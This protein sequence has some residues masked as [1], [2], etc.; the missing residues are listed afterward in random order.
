MGEEPL[1]RLRTPSI[2][3]AMLSDLMKKK[4]IVQ[5]VSDATPRS[6]GLKD[7]NDRCEVESDDSDRKGNEKDIGQLGKLQKM[8]GST[9]RL[10]LLHATSDFTQ[11]LDTLGQRFMKD[12]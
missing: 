12:E 5:R 6:I 7:D 9:P 8:I 1:S 2:G 10:N 4:N 11:T 3:R